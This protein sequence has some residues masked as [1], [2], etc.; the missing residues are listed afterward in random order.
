MAAE[1]TP[2]SLADLCAAAGVSKSALYPAFHSVCGEP[3][4]A[5]F[6]KRRLARSLFR[7]AMPIN[8]PRGDARDR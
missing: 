8:R 6:Q 5:Y 4:L 7:P 1:G 3:P 2:I